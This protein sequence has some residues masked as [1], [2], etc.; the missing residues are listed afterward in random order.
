MAKATNKGLDKR[1]ESRARYLFR[2]KASIQSKGW[3]AKHPQNGGDFLEENE[4]VGFFPNIGLELDRPDFLLT[5]G[6]KPC[7]TVEAKN[8]RAKID[9]AISEAIDYANRING[10]KKFRVNVAIGF[11][12]EA[13]KGYAVKVR[14][15]V[16]TTW[17]PLTS[18]GVELSAIP[19]RYEIERALLNNNGTTAVTV[20]DQ[21]E[22][23]EA[24]KEMG[25]VLRQVA[26]EPAERPR[27]IGALVA[28]MYSGTVDIAEK[29]SLKS[30][31]DLSKQAIDGIGDISAQK[32]KS[33]TDTLRLDPAAYKS[34]PAVI[35]RLV[36]ILERL[37]IRA[38]LHTG[39]DFLGM[40]YEAFLRYGNDNNS[41]GIV[42]TPRH[43]TRYC[44]DL[45][46]VGVSDKVIDLASGTGGFLV[47]AFDAMRDKALASKNPKKLLESIRESLSG[48]DTNH[49]IW[50]LAS[51]NMFFRGDGK[52]HIEHGSSLTSANRKAVKNRFTRAFL[53]PPFS[54]ENAPETDFIDASMDALVPGGLL[55]AVVFSSVFAADDTKKWRAEFLQKHK[56]LGMISLPDDLF[57]PTAAPTSIMIAEA[58]QPQSKSASVFMAKLMDDG[59]EKLKG[60]RVRKDS[61]HVQMDSISDAF[62]KHIAGKPFTSP[63]CVGLGASEILSGQEWAPENWLPQTPALGTPGVNHEEEVLSELFRA[64]AHFP[65]LTTCVLPTFG[66]SWSLLPPLPYGKTQ[67]LSYF[68]EIKNGKSSGE[69]GQTAGGSTPY[70]SSGDTTNSIISL[71]EPV[72]SEVFEEGGLTITAFGQAAIQPWPFVARGNGGSSVRVLAP[73]FRMS[74]RE[75][76]WF[77]GRINEQRWRF[78][79]TRMAIKGRLASPK[80]QLQS[81]PKALPDNQHTIKSK[82]DSFTKVLRKEAALW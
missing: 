32:K 76:I 61:G 78:F 62:H 66:K 19:S 22:F 1:A 4:I 11:A 23:I 7:V 58:H 27:V 54:Q 49:Q 14:I 45:V 52:S 67:P 59:F 42:F 36:S 57:Y 48:F 33:L 20:P 9:D 35:G 73:K 47:A 8:D 13:D 31:N 70:I 30:V 46:G 29:R 79:Y 6:S 24:A 60:K 28:A 50:A 53:N 72:E 74:L 5:I 12:G 80:F 25:S 75:L 55:V 63:L 40:F 21:S 17:K 81:P 41:L 34:L 65:G 39:V 51:L 43:I 56:L 68:F 37:N 2:E 15:L 77:A 44:V 69:K 10:A 64:A 3:N 18:N 16:G 26:I 38:V 82:I 71:V